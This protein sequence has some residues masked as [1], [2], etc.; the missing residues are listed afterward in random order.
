MLFYECLFCLFVSVT[1][2]LCLFVSGVCCVSVGGV[3]FCVVCVWHDRSVSYDVVWVL[4]H[5]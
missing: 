1:G 2:L 4:L 3:T 5:E